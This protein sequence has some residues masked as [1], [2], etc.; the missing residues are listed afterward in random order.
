MTSSSRGDIVA[1]LLASLLWATAFIGP[2]AV[3]P[4]GELLLVTGRYI[5]FGLCGLY[6]LV[7]GW[8]EVRKIPLRRM[9][10][11]WQLGVIGYLIF[12]I[13]VSYAVVMH[14]GFITAIIV[15]S[16]PIGIAVVGNFLER[17]TKWIVLLPPIALIFAGIFYISAS[18]FDNEGTSAGFAGTVLAV[19][20]ALIASGVWTYFVVA[21]AHVQR[22]WTNMPDPKYWA[23][24]VAVGAGSG[25]LIL[26]PL[27]LWITPAETFSAPV[28]IN[29]AFWIVWLGY[30]SS[31]YG[32]FIWVRAAARIPATLAGPL[33]ATEPVF[34]AILSLAWE[35]RL[36]TFPETIG[37]LLIILGVSIILVIDLRR[38][39]RER[40][41]V[42]DAL[43]EPRQ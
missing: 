14:G 26:L 30:F 19:V 18:Q 3:Q 7:G 22:S 17:R 24:F 21:N 8:Q 32:T 40:T 4:A 16:S 6:V 11:A 13:A 33:L 31:W 43:L 25:S 41:E 27:A 10:Y 38:S 28:L 37:S 39:S 35:Q 2:S 5:L 34:G 9:L 12:Y 15:G 20:L 1:G 23:A 36:P 29:L 42:Q